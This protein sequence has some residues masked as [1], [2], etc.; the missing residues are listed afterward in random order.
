MLM[1]QSR[2]LEQ[3]GFRRWAAKLDDE[4]P[5]LR[6]VVDAGSCRACARIEALSTSRVSMATGE[7]NFA[8]SGFRFRVFSRAELCQGGRGAASS[9]Q[10]AGR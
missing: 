2:L 3:A 10:R 1:Y 9:E 5:D 7:C 8:S 4:T 6:R